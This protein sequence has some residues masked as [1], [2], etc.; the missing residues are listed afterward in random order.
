[1]PTPP[2]AAPLAGAGPTPRRAFADM[3]Q[4]LREFLDKIVGARPDAATSADLSQDLSRWS[5]RLDDH[6]VDE[7]E[8]YYARIYRAPGQAQ[9]TVPSFVLAP[10]PDG[11]L[12]GQVTFGRF[13]LG[14]DGAA[15]GGA[16]ALLFD[17]ILGQTAAM[18]GGAARTAYLN[19][20]FRAL[21]PLDTPL[22]IRAWVERTE[23]RKRFA[24]CELRHGEVLCADA[25]A[26]F[27]TVNVEA[28]SRRSPPPASA[29][30]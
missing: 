2:N 17:Q 18:S 6:Q 20:N 1:M 14:W 28:V 30:R 8:Q 25:E 7:R 21:T 5:A 12:R 19:T 16:V 24:R 26:L 10:G 13:F 9:V 22:D 3:T 29:G 4:A 27:V 11:D 23:G 15:H